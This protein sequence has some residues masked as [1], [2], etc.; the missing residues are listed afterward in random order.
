MREVEDYRIIQGG[1]GAYVQEEVNKLIA[2]G[3]QLNGETFPAPMIGLKDLAITQAM[4]KYKDD[5]A[6]E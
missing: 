1:N 2:K 5:Q 6:E 3:Y 4:V